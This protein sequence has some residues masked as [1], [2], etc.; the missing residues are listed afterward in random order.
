MSDLTA[1]GWWATRP[2]GHVVPGVCVLVF[3]SGI[4]VVPHYS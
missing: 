1:G 4:L 2:Q 3:E